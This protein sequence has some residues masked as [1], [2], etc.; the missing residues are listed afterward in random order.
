MAASPGPHSQDPIANVVTASPWPH[1]QEVLFA[2]VVAVCA[3]VNRSPSSGPSSALH[4]RACLLFIPNHWYSMEP[5]ADRMVHGRVLNGACAATLLIKLNGCDAQC[6]DKKFN[7]ARD[8]YK[9]ATR[10]GDRAPRRDGL[11]ALGGGRGDRA[12][13]REGLRG[14]ATD[15]RNFRDGR[16]QSVEKI[17]IC[18]KLQPLFAKF[19]K[20][21]TSI[22]K[23]LE[24]YF[25]VF[26][27]N[28]SMQS[29]FTKLLA[30]TPKAHRSFR[31][32]LSIILENKV[33]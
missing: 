29:L 30:L 1:R 20:L 24:R 23:P 19:T 22:A 11:R 25:L 26:F 9:S 17:H 4:S 13:T 18:A 7:G 16:M 31:L 3:V 28:M 10:R 6:Y 12:P 5:A 15:R 8:Q 27:A 32:P 33:Q 14:R 21:Q 2:C